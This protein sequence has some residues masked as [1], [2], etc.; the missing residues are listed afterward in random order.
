MAKPVDQNRVYILGLLPG[1]YY[2]I[3]KYRMKNQ[4]ER[5]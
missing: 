5:V 4:I 2:Y 3:E 1:Q